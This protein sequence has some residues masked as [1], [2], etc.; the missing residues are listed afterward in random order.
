MKSI[1]YGRILKVGWFLELENHYI[2]TMMVKTVR[3][4]SSV[5]ATVRRNFDDPCIYMVLSCS[6][7]NC[8]LVEKN[9]N[10]NFFL[11]RLTVENW[12]NTFKVIKRN[13]SSGHHVSP[14]VKP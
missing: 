6:P 10:N 13:I 12:G 14:D 4:E 3:Q 7:I 11:R 5:D 9:V 2:G 1:V 8:L